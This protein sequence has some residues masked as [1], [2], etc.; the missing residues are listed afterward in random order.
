MNKVR[1]K[2]LVQQRLKINLSQYFFSQKKG[3]F[4][5]RDVKK[6]SRFINFSNQLDK[7]LIYIQ[8][9]RI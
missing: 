6:L 8:P 1:Y 7:Y 4:T 3:L 9:Y 2:I 5:I